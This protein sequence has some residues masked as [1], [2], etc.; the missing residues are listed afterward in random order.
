MLTVKQLSEELIKY[1]PE[2]QVNLVKFGKNPDLMPNNYAIAT[3][4]KDNEGVI[5]F[6]KS[7]DEMV[8]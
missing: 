8:E 6:I 1:P 3:I 4:E 2:T 7:L 5:I